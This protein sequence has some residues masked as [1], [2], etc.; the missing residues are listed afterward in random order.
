M[1]LSTHDWYRDVQY[2]CRTLSVVYWIASGCDR[3]RSDRRQ[4]R[5]PHR[6]LEPLDER[7]FRHAGGERRR[8]LAGR[9]FPT[10][11]GTRLLETVTD[12]I[13]SGVSSVLTYSLHRTLFPLKTNDGRP[14]IHNVAVRQIAHDPISCL[15]QITDVTAATERE[16]VLRERQNAR[17]DA[18]VESAP[19]AI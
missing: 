10:L 19:D 2:S 3:C 5:T 1:G 9:G 7:R 6:R 17:Y 12:A 18:V 13:T 16:R 15:I 11:A 4:F 8:P 14:M